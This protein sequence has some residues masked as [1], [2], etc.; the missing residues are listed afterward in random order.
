M[1]VEIVIRLL[2]AAFWGALIGAEREY[3]GKAAGLR[4][5]IMISVGACFFTFMSIW[6]GGSGNPD[7]IASN[8]VTGLGFLCAGVIFRSDS[9]VSG[10][11]TAATIWSVAAVSMG[12]GA[13]YYFASA[14]AALMILLILTM[15]TVLQDKIDISNEHKILRITFKCGE[16]GHKICKELFSEYDIKSKLIV[17]RRNQDHITL[18]WQVHASKKSME[19]LSQALL[20]DP[21]FEELI[22]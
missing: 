20:Q 22:L 5:T 6:I 15:L 13:G 2:L 19:S 14:C 7:R 17:Q 4:T 21:I 8:I 11:T 9:H 16:D 12:V 3:R 1:E 10:I 18:E